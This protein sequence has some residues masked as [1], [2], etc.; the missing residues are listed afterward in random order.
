MVGTAHPRPAEEDPA[1][2]P[3]ALTGDVDSQGNPE[4][5]AG[6]ANEKKHQKQLVIAGLGIGIV[7][8][9]V[10]LKSR[11]TSSSGASTS[12]PLDDLGQGTVADGSTSQPNSAQSALNNR[13]LQQRLLLEKLEAKF[14]AQQ[15][16]LEKLEHPKK[17]AK[18]GIAPAPGLHHPT[19][20]T[21]KHFNP[22][23]PEKGAPP[24]KKNPGPVRVGPPVKTH[25]QAVDG[26]SE[27]SRRVTPS[28]G[29][30]TSVY[31]RT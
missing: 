23:G 5:V 26:M 15:K 29:S 13:V 17:H 30:K 14:R 1:A 12:A 20:P 21:H 22:G 25:Q 6:K 28:R 3:D 18:H 10:T 2:A 16:L 11:G 4:T 8:L 19:A 24:H 31:S 7:A 27:S 9:V